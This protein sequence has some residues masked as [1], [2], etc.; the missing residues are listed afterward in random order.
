MEFTQAE[1]SVVLESLLNTDVT[2][3]NAE[4]L[5]S[6]I[7]KFRRMDSCSCDQ[8]ASDHLYC[9]VHGHI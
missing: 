1:I 7:H 5:A 2:M 4:L 3:E 9:A 8:L 6:A